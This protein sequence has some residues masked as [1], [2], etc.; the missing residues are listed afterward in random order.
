MNEVTYL[1]ME[2]YFP[3]VTS[4]LFL[5]KKKKKKKEEINIFQSPDPGSCTSLWVYSSDFKICTLQMA[6][7]A[8]TITCPL[9]R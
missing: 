4:K 2:A 8:K 6:L 7:G 3:E 9:K 5:K 1:T